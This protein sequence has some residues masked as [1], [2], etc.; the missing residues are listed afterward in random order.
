MGLGTWQT[1]GIVGS[2][3]WLPIGYAMGRGTAVQD[4]DMAAAAYRFCLKQI[5]GD[6]ASCRPPFE[7][8]YNKAVANRWGLEFAMPVS[9]LALFWFGELLVRLRY[10]KMP[11]AT[12]PWPR[13]RLSGTVRA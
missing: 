2:L 10:W 4:R 12:D 5:I 3:L 1:F 9:V 11:G 13:R 6:E 7:R 8:D